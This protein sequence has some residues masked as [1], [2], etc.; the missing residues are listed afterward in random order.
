MAKKEKLYF[1][2]KFNFAIF[3]LRV[4]HADNISSQLQL[5]QKKFYGLD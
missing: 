3:T 4:P 5:K 1:L 2:T